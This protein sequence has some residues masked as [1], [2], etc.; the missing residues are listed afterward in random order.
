MAQMIP[1][2]VEKE[3]PPTPGEILRMMTPQSDRYL[4]TAIAVQV[5]GVRLNPA[6]V[7]DYVPMNVGYSV[8]TEGGRMY[9]HEILVQNYLFNFIWR[10]ALSD[11]MNYRIDHWNVNVGFSQPHINAGFGIHMLTSDLPGSTTR[12]MWNVAFILNPD[13]QFRLVMTKRN[14]NQP[15]FAGVRLR[16]VQSIGIGMWPFWE[17]DLFSF[18]IDYTL[19]NG[20]RLADGGTKFGID[21]KIFDFLRLYALYEFTPI[22]HEQMGMVGIRL[23]LPYTSVTVG[24]IFD[25]FRKYMSSEASVFVAPENRV[26]Q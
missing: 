16:G 13:P 15:A 19:P 17:R 8:F 1:A 12:Y 4:L 14:I 20:V 6:I 22:R 5:R 11:Q 10:R 2:G 18:G 26:L 3:N 21:T 7:G 24:N 23:F 25:T 9:E